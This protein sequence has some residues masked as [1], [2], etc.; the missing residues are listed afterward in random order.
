M[1][2]TIPFTNHRIHVRV[3]LNLKT[4][5]IE[6]LIIKKKSMHL[7]EFRFRTEGT[8]RR[9]QELAD[10]KGAGEARSAMDTSQR[11]SLNRR[12]GLNPVPHFIKAIVKQIEDVMKIHE[13]YDSKHYQDELRHN[14]LVTQMLDVQVWAIEKMMLWLADHSLFILEFQDSRLEICHH[15]WIRHLHMEYSSCSVD[16]HRRKDLAIQI[17]RHKGLLSSSDPNEMLNASD[18][19][20]MNAAI[21]NCSSQDIHVCL[22]L[23]RML[24]FLMQAFSYL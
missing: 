1:V 10:H 24:L 18:H 3:N 6:D 14:R 4:E 23:V 9:L 22:C 7:S 11:M 2:L 17:L 5:T 15:R 19:P 12:M 13:Q 16:I 8:K 20:L 21:G